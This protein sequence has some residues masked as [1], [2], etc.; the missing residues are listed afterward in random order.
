MLSQMPGVT[1][2]NFEESIDQLTLKVAVD[3]EGST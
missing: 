1:V 2:D 3:E